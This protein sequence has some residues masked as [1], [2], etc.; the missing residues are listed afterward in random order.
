MVGGWF[1]TLFTPDPAESSHNLSLT[2]NNTTI[3]TIRNPKILGVTFDP[4]L[5]FSTHINTIA[6]KAKKTTNILKSLTTTKW[7]QSIETISQTYKTITR[8]ILEYANPAWS[9]ITSNTSITKLQTIQN[10]ALRIATGCVADTNSNH[11][12]QETKVLPLTTHLKL[13]ASNYRQKVN[14]PTHPNHQLTRKP[15]PP[16]NKKTTIF[17]NLFSQ[18]DPN[19]N[20][21]DTIRANIKTNHTLAV[22]EHQTSLPLNKLTNQPYLD[23]HPS[24]T[25]LP[26]HRRC[27]LRQLRTD[28]SPF[29]HAHR[30]LQY[31]TQCPS[32]LCPLCKLAPHDTHHLFN[33]PTLPTTHTVTNL[34][35][36]PCEVSKLLDIW[37]SHLD[38][39]Q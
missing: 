12:H 35:T 30:H 22:L 20:T 4:K 26:R 15:N 38:P 13:H 37:A 24:E 39:S 23:P 2:I 1:P 7:G 34:W 5:T 6:E 19:Y 36:S 14:L 27:L 11:L 31:P 10:T 17:N 3:P 28:K 25:S 33:C 29:L 32:P 18:P 9:T 16:R 8:P 21:P